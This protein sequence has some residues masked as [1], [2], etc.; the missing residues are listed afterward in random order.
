M[1]RLTFGAQR[2]QW[3]GPPWRPEKLCLQLLGPMP[4]AAHHPAHT[5]VLIITT[6]LNA[7]WHCHACLAGRILDLASA[8]PCCSCVHCIAPDDALLE[9]PINIVKT[10]FADVWLERV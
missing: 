10:Y 4:D 6:I 8:D 1:G 2:R 9:N 3:P 7:E 5:N